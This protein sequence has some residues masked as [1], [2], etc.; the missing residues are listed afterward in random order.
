MNR[1]Q[2]ISI[3]VACLVAATFFVL[4]PIPQQYTNNFTNEVYYKGSKQLNNRAAIGTILVGVGF[5]FYYR[6]ERIEQEE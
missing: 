5:F 1:N 6:R 4:R 2:K 3:L